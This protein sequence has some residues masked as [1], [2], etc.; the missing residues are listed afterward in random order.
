MS[1]TTTQADGTCDATDGEA[2]ELEALGDWD[3]AAHPPMRTN[4]PM[5]PVAL[6]IRRIERITNSVGQLPCRRRGAGLAV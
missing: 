3:A 6:S 4:A 2:L 1:A 5:A